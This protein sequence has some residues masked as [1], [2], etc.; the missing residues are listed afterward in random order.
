MMA[1]FSIEIVEAECIGC[2]ACEGACDNWET[3]EKDGQYKAQPK[4]KDIDDLGCN[5][6]AAE[7][8][9]VNCIHI[10]E[11]ETGKKLI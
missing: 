11:N 2:A 1:K 5:M 10:S 8:C 3:V 7:I 9:P 4:N 6:E